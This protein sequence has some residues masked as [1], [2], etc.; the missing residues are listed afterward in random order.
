MDFELLNIEIIDTYDNTRVLINEKT[1]I[2]APHLIY[3]GTEDKFDYIFSSELHFNLLVTTGENA[4]FEHL[5]T[6]DEKRYEVNL[7]DVSDEINPINIWSGHL[8]PEQFN[9]PY[10]SG[11]FFVHFIA[12]DGLGR[13]KG[14]YLP[15]EYYSDHKSLISIISACLEF[16]FNQFDIYVALAIQ[17]AEIDLKSS[18]FLL[19]TSSYF[20]E[21][22]KLTV[23]DI[24]QNILVSFGLKIFQWNNNWYLIGINRW[25]VDSILTEKYSYLG[26]F[27]SDT[28]VNRLIKPVYFESSSSITLLPIFKSVETLWENKYDKSI[29][30]SDIVYQPSTTPVDFSVNVP[31]DHWTVVG[32]GT[33][34]LSPKAHE[35]N[36]YS[37]SFFFAY[38]SPIY[39][40]P[41]ITEDPWWLCLN[42]STVNPNSDYIELTEK[43]YV[44]VLT[45]GTASLSLEMEFLSLTTF[46]SSSW[47]VPPA[48]DTSGEISTAYDYLFQYELLL[49]DVVLISN[50]PSFTNY[51]QY[52]YKLTNEEG[53]KIRGKLKI[54]KIPI[55][56]PGYLQLRISFPETVSSW[57]NA[58]SKKTVFEKIELKFET[59][60]NEIITTDR[61]VQTSLIKLLTVFHADDN[62][63]FTNRQILID[64]NIAWGGKIINIPEEYIE[65]TTFNF[66]EDVQGT[67]VY[68][69]VELTIDS[70]N[71]VLYDVDAVYVQRSGVLPYE[72]IP[73]VDYIIYNS[74]G[75]YYFRMYSGT[76]WIYDVDVLY[77]HRNAHQIVT[78]DKRYLRE[79]W[80]R[81]GITEEVRFLEAINKI[82]HDVT[83]IPLKILDGLMYGII[84]PLDILE[85]DFDGVDKYIPVKLDIDLV[86]GKTS[87]ILIDQ[88]TNEV[89]N[90]E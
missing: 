4:V 58:S 16:T 65:L 9:E 35:I 19:N 62:K 84:C 22:K 43:L 68:H 23:Y 32:S 64:D 10:K 2:N 59:D 14:Y 86:G 1:E 67:V 7:L 29:L 57:P 63:D 5:Y 71:K 8:L 49:N 89:T 11:S 69:E 90:Y 44:D 85:F 21:D 34:T 24:L 15:D 46:D 55:S 27:L 30:P 52:N 60:Q 41:V 33:I 48:D 38:Y 3:N 81:F 79:R 61:D 25:D 76:S 56:E 54:D 12:T 26:V 28:S 70:Y 77:V 37:N 80:K 74:E 6:S 18:D 51:Q 20:N 88:T 50:K 39:V 72:H 42:E 40:T 82:N 83:S 73:A 36:Y 53:R 17:N 66:V 31:V 13:L 47:F 78:N 75:K 87:V 45:D